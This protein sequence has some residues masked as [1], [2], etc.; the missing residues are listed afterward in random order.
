LRQPLFIWVLSIEKKYIIELTGSLKRH[1]VATQFSGNELTFS[2]EEN[3][4]KFFLA[5]PDFKYKANETHSIIHLDQLIKGP[6]KIIA[7]VLSRLKI[8]STVY[9]RSCEVRKVDKETAVKFFKK[10]HLMNA[11]QSAFN[12]GLFYKDELIAL[13]SFSKGRKMNRL[14]EDQRSFELIRFCSKIGITVT[15]GLSKLLKNFCDEKK[16]GD[17][18]TYVDKHLSDGS[19]FIRAGFEKHSETEP[20]YFLV[21]KISFERTSASE[22]EIFDHSKFYLTRNAGNVKLVYTP[23]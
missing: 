14:R 12:F 17:I 19:S 13:A 10:Y 23:S 16:A 3:K 11:T 4:I 6:D 7:L 21:N 18:M 1:R 20:N 8:N 5:E 9:A 15:G 2:K 22:D